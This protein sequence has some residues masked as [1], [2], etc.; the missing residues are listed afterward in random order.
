MR[1]LTDNLHAFGQSRAAELFYSALLRVQ[2][3]ALRP[4]FHAG[5]RGVVA[6]GLRSGQPQVVGRPIRC[7][8]FLAFSV[9]YYSALCLIPYAAFLASRWKPSE[10]SFPKL[11][12]GILGTLGAVALFSRQNLATRTMSSAFGPF[13]PI[14]PC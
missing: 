10:S 7:T 1:R 6:L 5:G 11:L 2:R 4:L 3:Q 12:A 13:L 8:F 9:H 14:A